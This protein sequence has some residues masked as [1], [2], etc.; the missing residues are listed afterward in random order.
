MSMNYLSG[1]EGMKALSF[2]AGVKKRSHSSHEKTFIVNIS[3]FRK[4]IKEDHVNACKSS[5][6]PL[7]H[8]SWFYSHL[9][10]EKQ[11]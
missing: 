4:I 6:L 2:S 1:G 8:L 3:N 7:K 9:T 5:L 11:H 10:S